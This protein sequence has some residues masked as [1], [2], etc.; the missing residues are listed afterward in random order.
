M[1]LCEILEYRID[2]LTES[3]VRENCF[4]EMFENSNLLKNFSSKIWCYTVNQSKAP[5]KP[6]PFL[7]CSRIFAGKYVFPPIHP[8]LE[9]VKI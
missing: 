9:V 6:A 1:K 3:L 8:Q 5:T 2:A 7:P 4:R